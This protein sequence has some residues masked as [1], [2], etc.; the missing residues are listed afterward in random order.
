MQHFPGRDP[1]DDGGATV[2]EGGST[3]ADN[4]WATTS[5]AP[6]DTST[7]GSPPCNNKFRFSIMV[8]I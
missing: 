5:T 7:P 6:S 8:I 4:E 2:A 3:V 1:G